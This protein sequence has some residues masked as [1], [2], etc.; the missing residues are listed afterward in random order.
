MKKLIT[1]FLIAFYLQANAQ[2]CLGSGFCNNATNQYP[3]TTF[4]TTSSSW[5]TVSVYMNAGNWTLFNV[6]SGHTYEWTYCEAYGGSSTAW[7]AQLTLKNYTSG[8]NLCFSDNGCGTNGNAP[9]IS[10][11]ATYTGVVEIL[12]SQ[13]NCQSNTGKPYTTLV[14]R[15]ASGTAPLLGIDV[16]SY[17]GT[18]TWSQVKGAGYVYAWAKSSEGVSITDSEFKNNIVNGES[19]SVKMGAYHYARPE[20]NTAA[21]E[22]TYFLSVAGTYIKACELPPVLDLEDPPSGPTL[23]ASFTSAQLTTWVQDWMTAVQTKTGIAP[24]L[25]TEGSIASY[26]NSSLTTYKLWIADPDASPTIQPSSIGVWT[27]W[28]FK[29]YEWNGTVPGISGTGDVD[30][31]VFNGDM[32]AFDQ[33]IGCTTTGIAEK[34]SGADFVIY[35]NPTS[36]SFQVGYDDTNGQESIFMYDVNGRLILSQVISPKTVIDISSLEKGIYN[37]SIPAKEGVIHKRL[38]IAR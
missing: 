37:I 27:S 31:D 14:W 1:L 6:T 25:Y 26:L 18:I 10:W 28:A 23:V 20:D 29:Q 38:V 17:Q 22:A 35:P 36:N 3:S 32:T 19:A 12:T 13:S 9:Y 4:S 8:A 2:E 24:I 34:I 11:T 15:D 16:S 5:T 21:A 33:L 30:L 7:D